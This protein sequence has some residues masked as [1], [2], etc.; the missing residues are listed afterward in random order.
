MEVKVGTDY[1]A[2]DIAK[3]AVN[4]RYKMGKPI[5]N[6]QLQK[7]L[8]F[9]QI[10]FARNTGTLVFSDEFEAWPYGPV[11]RDVYV[12]FSDCGGFPIRQE[13]P[14]EVKDSLHSFLDAGIDL[15]AAKSP[16]ELVRI[17]HA[18][19]SPWDIVYNHDGRHKGVISNELIMES[20]G[21]GGDE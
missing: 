10:V 16:W 12:E 14:I 6:L 21:G 2:M 20:A 1:S 7:I 5:S 9:L 15:L 8:Y 18:V 17:S 11:I 3:Y 19:G 4:K 13:F